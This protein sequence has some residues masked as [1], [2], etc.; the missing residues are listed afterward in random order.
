MIWQ[1]DYEHLTTA[2]AFYDEVSRRSGVREWPDLQKLFESSS[3]DAVSGGDAELWNACV[4]SHRGFQLGLDLLLILPRIALE[5]GFAEIGVNEAL[6]PVFPKQFLDSK[7]AVKLTRALAPPPKASS[8]EIV[9]PSGGAFYAREAPHLPLL[10]D[11]GDHFKAGQPLFIIEVM[12][13]FNKVYAPCDGTVIENRMADADGEI[14]K[15]GQ[16]VFKIQPDEV[17]VEESDESIRER[18]TAVTRALL[19]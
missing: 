3:N 19:P 13:M 18:R 6:E 14:V 12:K 10:I 15:A 4:A 17:L 11:V 16:V 1:H 7:L 5:S 2:T 8:D 9:T